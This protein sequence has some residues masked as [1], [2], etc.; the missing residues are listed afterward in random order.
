MSYLGRDFDPIVP[1]ESEIFTID[2]VNDLPEDDEINTVTFAIA[3][4]TGTDA[5]ASTRLIG[6]PTILDTTVLHRVGD[7]V[8]NVV[9]RLTATVTT[10]HSN[11]LKLYSHINCVS[12]Y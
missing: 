5:S 2:F 3:V 8:A 7:C 6:S 4:V 11:T 12:P 10:T 9:Y 1:G